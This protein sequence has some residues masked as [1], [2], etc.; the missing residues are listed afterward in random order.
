MRTR[1]ASCIVWDMNEPVRLLSRLALLLAAVVSVQPLFAQTPEGCA[2]LV[3]AE[4]VAF[5][6]L[7]VL[8][9]LGAMQPQGMIYALRSD[10][11]PINVGQGLVAGNVRLRVGKRPRPLVLR[12]NVGDC[13]RIEFQNLL[14]PTPVDDQQPF[15]RTASVHV[16]GMQLVGSIDSDSS[17]VGQNTSSLAAP[18]QS[19][20]Y[21]L[22]AEREGGYLMYSAA[23]QVGGEGDSGSNSPGLFGAV[24]VEPPGAEWYRSQITAEEREYATGLIMPTGQP[25]IDLNTAVYPPGHPRAGVPILKMLHNGDI[26]HS[27]LTAVITGPN[28]GRFPPGTFPEVAVEPDREQPFREFVTIYHDELGA[29]H[30]PSTMARAASARR[31]W[32]TGSA[33]DRW[34]I[35]PNANS[36]ISS[37]PHGPLA[38]RP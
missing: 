4:V 7:I 23:A 35:A 17:N 18:N 12:M 27:D 8:N 16:V 33:S 10:V 38:I 28:Q 6:Q 36:R 37:S 2:R 34:P 24:V 22:Y 1:A 31:S 19:K 11:V 21:T 29:V 30:S 5:D 3:R 26:I 20:V 32:R 15:T 14:N 9:R 13:L 25:V